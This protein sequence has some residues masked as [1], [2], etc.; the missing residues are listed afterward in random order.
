MTRTWVSKQR[1]RIQWKKCVVY[2]KLKRLA[3]KLSDISEKA[4]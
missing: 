3:V 4:L 2:V 1:L